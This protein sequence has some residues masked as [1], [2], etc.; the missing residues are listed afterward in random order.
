MCLKGG[1][2]EENKQA[3]RQTMIIYKRRKI[4]GLIRKE[5]KTKN[6]ELRPYI[7]YN[8]RFMIKTVKCFKTSL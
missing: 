3:D 5:K 8:E 2:R 4:D 7:P 6:K 1:R